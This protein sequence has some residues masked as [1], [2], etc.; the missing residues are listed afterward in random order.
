MKT[1]SLQLQVSQVSKNAN[2]YETQA[3]DVIGNAITLPQEEVL[4][5]FNDVAAKRERFQE[6]KSK[7]DNNEFSLSKPSQSSV[8]YK[9]LKNDLDK[10]ET[11]LVRCLMNLVYSIA[12]KFYKSRR[13]YGIKSVTIDEIVEYGLNGLFDA[14]HNFKRGSKYYVS[15]VKD[16]IKFAIMF[17]LRQDSSD[18]AVMSDADI[19]KFNRI[20]KEVAKESKKKQLDR[21]SYEYYSLFEDISLKEGVSEDS[22]LAYYQMDFCL[23]NANKSEDG[24][25]NYARNTIKTDFDV[26]CCDSHL[27]RMYLEDLV[28]L[29]ESIL[30]DPMNADI[31][32]RHLV[33]DQTFDRIAEIYGFSKPAA[34]KRY[35]KAK[36]QLQESKEFRDY[37]EGYPD[38]SSKESSY[39]DGYTESSSDYTA[40]YNSYAEESVEKT[41]LINSLNEHYSLEDLFK[42]A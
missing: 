6:L 36:K 27:D 3:S 37:Y 14:I 1:G 35:D 25:R 17:G 29:M 39:D 41:A 40:Y 33:L 2:N 19:K 28:D 18:G 23:R 7:L 32:Y 8:Q 26:S 4:E 9:E 12:Q 16:N 11:K 34:K 15:F 5:L 13:N 21:D 42:V 31:V 38:I 30:Q 20:E 22:A 10:L 24:L